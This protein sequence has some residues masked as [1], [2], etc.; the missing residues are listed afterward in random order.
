MCARSQCESCQTQLSA[1]ELVPLLSYVL[2][3]GRC[4]HCGARIDRFHPAVEAA[5]FAVAV[6]ICAVDIGIFDDPARAAVDCLLGWTLLALAGMDAKTRLLPDELTLPLIP[7]GLFANWWLAREALTDCLLG[8]AIGW[9]VFVGIAWVWRR[10]K[11]EE[12]LGGGDA[13]L[14]AATGA[15]VGWQGLPSVILLAALA[16]IVATMARRRGQQAFGTRIAF[17]PWL[18]LAALIVRLGTGV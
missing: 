10:L 16:A 4:R 6:L 5:A 15:W 14:L 11:E 12:G 13:K 1:I 8:A 2:Q 7:D 18:A 3:C 17:G 9:F